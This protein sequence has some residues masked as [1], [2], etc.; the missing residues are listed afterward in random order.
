M[1]N[2]LLGVITLAVIVL[3]VVIIRVLTDLRADLA[4]VKESA[5][6]TEESLIPL[7]QELQMTAKSLRTVTDNVGGV[8]EDVRV[9]SC[10][11]RE[12]GENVRQVSELVGNF[13]R[14]SALTVT[15]VKAGAITAIGFLLKNMFRT[16]NTH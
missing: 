13:G 11:I 3:T 12:I 2:I 15:G 16:K 10:S 14:T 5:L 1:T 7:L 6:K 8:T 4:V 9:F